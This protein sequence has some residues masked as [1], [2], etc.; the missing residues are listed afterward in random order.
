MSSVYEMKST[1][2]VSFQMSFMLSLLSCLKIIVVKFMYLMYRFA[3]KSIRVLH[4][5]EL[6]SAKQATSID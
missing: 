5:V 1:T 4:G 6:L 2:M 3:S